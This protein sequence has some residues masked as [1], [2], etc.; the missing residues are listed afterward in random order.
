MFA[1]KPTYEIEV[2][3]DILEETDGP[4]LLHGLQEINGREII[5]PPRRRD[6]PD[7]E[8]LEARYEL[9]RSSF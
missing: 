8:R 3:A 5:L 4:M 6:R 1:I 7:R 2:R 9:F